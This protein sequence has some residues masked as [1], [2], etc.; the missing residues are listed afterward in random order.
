MEPLIKTRRESLLCELYS[1]KSGLIVH[2]S[3]LEDSGNSFLF[4]GVADVGKSTLAKK[5]NG[6]MN[7]INDDMNIL[8]F[9][10]A[11]I[12][13]STYFTQAENRGHHYLINEDVRGTLK[14]VLFPV[15]ELKKDSY[16]ELL[17][18]EGFIWKVLLTCVAPP[19]SGKD[20]LFPNYYKMIDC[21]MDSVPFFYIH[22]N[23]KDSPEAIANLLREIN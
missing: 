12:E 21:V 4:A 2:S 15:K 22:H 5:L 14:A 8:K 9:C 17:S 7:V 10:E 13:V 19:I 20:H 1:S 16:L 23:L 18:D 6:L 11:G 3:A